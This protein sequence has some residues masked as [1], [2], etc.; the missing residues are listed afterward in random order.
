MGLVGLVWLTPR[1]HGL[2]LLLPTEPNRSGAPDHMAICSE[3]EICLPPTPCTWHRRGV[4]PKSSELLVERGVSPS[5]RDTRAPKADVKTQSSCRGVGL[6]E[7]PR[8]LAD[9]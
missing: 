4:L 8:G 7:A 2:I 3:P 1:T 9:L 6:G 5:K